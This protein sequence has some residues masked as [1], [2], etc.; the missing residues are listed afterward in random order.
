MH[1]YGFY[2]YADGVKYDG[3]FEADR[4]QGF[5]IYQWTDGRKYEGYWN[6]GKQHGLGI[7]EGSDKKNVK[8]GIWDNG[9]RMKWFDEE[10]I[11]LINQGKYDYTQHFK[12][13]SD[14]PQTGITF[15]RTDEW[16]KEMTKIKN[17][18]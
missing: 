13:P 9:K 2:V 7:Y 5:G 10:T 16:E 14:H 18:L 8:Y 3:Q 6:K 11:N 4:K 15:K 12:I 1:G 17:I